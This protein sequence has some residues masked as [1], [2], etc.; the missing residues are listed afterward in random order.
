[1]GGLR[2]FRGRVG[3]QG[4]D[5]ATSVSGLETGGVWAVLVAGGKWIAVVVAFLAVVM[6]VVAT[7]ADDVEDGVPQIHPDLPRGPWRR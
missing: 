2:E 7:Q 6:T 4:P 1:M 5:V 3:A